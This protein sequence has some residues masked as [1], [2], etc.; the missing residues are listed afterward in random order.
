M[1]AKILDK[2]IKVTSILIIILIILLFVNYSNPSYYNDD[3]QQEIVSPDV[4]LEDQKIGPL[5]SNELSEFLE[6][7]KAEKSTPPQ[8]AYLAPNSKKIIP[9][10]EG[11]SID[12][13]ETATRLLTA[14]KG[15]Q[16]KLSS[17]KQKP[18]ITAEFINS[19]QKQWINI[20]TEDKNKKEKLKVSFLSTYT[21]PINNDQKERVNNIEIALDKLNGSIIKSGKEFSWNKQLGKPI[22]EKGYQ[23]APVYIGG[24]LQP[25]YGGGICQVSSTL[26]NTL[27]ISELKVTER[28]PHS[29]K[30]NYVPPNRDAT[31][32]Y[33][34]KDLKFVNNKELPILILG[35]IIDQ[36]VVVFLLQIHK[37]K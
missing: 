33:E 31:I 8:N 18:Q 2:I 13:E 28:H 20:Q 24:E 3:C 17:Q 21:T 22:P 23:K 11:E 29:F 16:V 35:E 26:Y 30:V 7:I 34:F 37:I 6:E 9:E 25:D 5:N 27:L 32:V 36:N 14:T 10:K 1:S 15:S 4:K 12:I 19:N